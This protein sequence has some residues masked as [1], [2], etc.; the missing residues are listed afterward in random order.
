MK[1]AG[2]IGRWTSS[3]MEKIMKDGIGAFAHPDGLVRLHRVESGKK[4]TPTDQP[5]VVVD[6]KD[7]CQVPTCYVE[8]KTMT[9]KGTGICSENHRKLRDGELKASEL[10]AI[11][12]GISKESAL[13]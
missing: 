3:D 5:P 9:Y 4:Y 6:A 13:P 11:E 10:K 2:H 12:Q 8:I 7:V 1:L